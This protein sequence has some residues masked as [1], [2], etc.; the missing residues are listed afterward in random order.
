[1]DADIILW[2]I[3]TLKPSLESSS[4]ILFSERISRTLQMTTSQTLTSRKQ[5]Q[6]KLI[7]F[8]VRVIASQRSQC[9]GRGINNFPFL[10]YLFMND[11][12]WRMFAKHRS[13][14][15]GGRSPKLHIFS[16]TLRG[17]SG[18]LLI[19]FKRPGRWWKS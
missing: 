6:W 5:Y 14:Q 4:V 16:F 2:T 12:E 3:F 9:F 10:A 7:L 8:S 15:L 1:M 13:V 18:H 19:L 17:E 11:N